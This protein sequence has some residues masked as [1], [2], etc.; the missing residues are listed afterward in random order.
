MYLDGASCGYSFHTHDGS[1]FAL[2]DRPDRIGRNLIAMEPAISGCHPDFSVK[3]GLL[4]V[5]GKPLAD[6]TAL[7]AAVRLNLCETDERLYGDFDPDVP[8]V[9]VAIERDEM[10]QKP[11]LE[12]SFWDD[13]DIVTRRF[14]QHFRIPTRDGHPPGYG[15]TVAPLP[16]EIIPVLFSSE[17]IS[18]FVHEISP[19]QE[20]VAQTFQILHLC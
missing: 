9:C 10:C 5:A 8:H 17:R 19:S 14:K 3:I 11:L 7:P 6:L 4:R 12:G 2:E 20:V 1:A 16:G 18:T 15:H 13:N